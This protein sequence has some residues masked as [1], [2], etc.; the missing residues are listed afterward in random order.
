MVAK[1]VAQGFEEIIIVDGNSTD[2]SL[3]LIKLLQKKHLETNIKVVVN[4]GVQSPFGAFVTGC[5]STD[6]EYISC[7]SADDYPLGNHLVRMKEAIKDFP[8]VDLYTCNALV[9]REG[10]QYKRTLLPFTAYISPDYAVKIFKAGFAKN[11]NLCGM[12]MKRDMVLKCWQEGG[13][14]TKAN[15]DCMFA[16]FMAFS[17]GFVNLHEPLAVYR[18]YPNSWG[19]TG[20]A[21]NIVHAISKH[22]EMYLKYPEVYKRAVASGMWGKGVMWKSLIVLWGIMK[23]PKWIRLGF[24]DW[25]YAYNQ[26]VE[27]L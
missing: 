3:D 26:E 11:I 27:K 4:K 14:E 2:N 17:K 25:F 5:H 22:K 18:S 15:F 9:F 21:K 6:A 12:L 16:F 23:L 20:K 19:A 24:F 13:K 1:M 8:L 7:W 10:Y